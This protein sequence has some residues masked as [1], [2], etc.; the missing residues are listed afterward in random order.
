[1]KLYLEYLLKQY[2]LTVL[3]GKTGALLCHCCYILRKF[4]C[5]IVC[6]L[7]C[8]CEFNFFI[9]RDS[10]LNV[11][12]I[13]LHILKMIVFFCS[14]YYL[15]CVI[16]Y[17]DLLL[18]QWITISYEYVSCKY[19]ND[20]VLFEHILLLFLFQL[21]YIGLQFYNVWLILPII[22][23]VDSNKPWECKFSRQV[24][25]VNIVISIYITMT[26]YILLIDNHWLVQVYTILK[27]VCVPSTKF[28]SFLH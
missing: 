9:K 2:W 21:N 12:V 7:L 24:V 23:L 20:H 10:I 14:I 19:Y 28:N 13:I 15:Y 1:M 17:T 22:C 11:R 27:A 18:F 8:I 3:I 6:A 26:D 4:E 5:V 25:I 16:L